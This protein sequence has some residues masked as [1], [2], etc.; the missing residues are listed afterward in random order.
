M[1]IFPDRVSRGDPGT[2][3]GCG[4][5]SDWDD[6]NSVA[7]FLT[8]FANQCNNH[9]LCY[10]NCSETKESCDDEFLDMMESECNDDWDFSSKDPCK[11][12][13]YGMYSLVRDYG[14]DAFDASRGHCT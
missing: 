11:T 10:T 12:V 6:I 7:D 9:D 5:A 2:V 13:A 4:P 1:H 14:Q 3:N 8:G